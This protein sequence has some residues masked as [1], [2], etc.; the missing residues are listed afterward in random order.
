MDQQQCT[1]NRTLDIT[2]LTDSDRQ[3]VCM[4]CGEVLRQAAGDQPAP[5]D[6]RLPSGQLAPESRPA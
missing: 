3:Q 2:I 5:E 6:A 1:H 4:D